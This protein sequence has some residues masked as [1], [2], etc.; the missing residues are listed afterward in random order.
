MAFLPTAPFLTLLRN[1][2]PPTLAWRY[3]A[4]H[5]GSHLTTVAPPSASPPSSS[6]SQAQGHVT[7]L[8][9]TASPPS[10]Q[11]SRLNTIFVSTATR[12]VMAVTTL[13][14][15]PYAAPTHPTVAGVLVPTPRGMIPVPPPPVTRRA[16]PAHTPRLSVSHVLALMKHTLPSALSVLPL[17]PVRRV[18]R[19]TRCTSTGGFLLPSRGYVPSPSGAPAPLYPRVG[20]LSSLLTRFSTDCTLGPSD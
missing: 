17:S 10:Q 5:A 6:P 12:N 7:L 4:R 19:M 11:H 2:P 13:A 15:T 3:P 9:A 16:A 8:P 14:I 18:G 20:D 1:S